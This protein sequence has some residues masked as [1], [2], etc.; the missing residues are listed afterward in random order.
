MDETKYAVKV[1][2]SKLVAAH[3]LQECRIIQLDMASKGLVM[4]L[5]EI[6]IKKGY[7]TS[8]QA[9][10]LRES[11]LPQRSSPINPHRAHGSLLQRGRAPSPKKLVRQPDLHRKDA[12]SKNGHVLRNRLAILSLAFS[13][14]LVVIASVLYLSLRSKGSTDAPKSAS[15]QSSTATKETV[16]EIRAALLD[17]DFVLATEILSRERSTLANAMLKQCELEIEQHAFEAIAALL[18]ANDEDLAIT[19]IPRICSR[20]ATLKEKLRGIPNAEQKVEAELRR[21]S[22]IDQADKAKSDLDRR[23][24]PLMFAREY[25]E[26][27]RIYKRELAGTLNPVLAKTLQA[28]I[29]QVERLQ[30]MAPD[31]GLPAEVEPLLRMARAALDRADMVNASWILRSA[32]EKAPGSAE[33]HG[34]F[35]W[36]HLMGNRYIDARS[37][38]DAA[39]RLDTNQPE[40]NY[41]VGFLLHQEHQHEKAIGYLDKTLAGRPAFGFAYIMRAYCCY[42][43]GRFVQAHRDGKEALGHEKGSQGIAYAYRILVLSLT[44]LG[45]EE[46][47]LTEC[48][49]WIAAQPWS[50]APY[51]HRGDLYLRSNKPE[52]AKADY[53]RALR[54][55]PNDPSIREKLAKAEELIRGGV[56]GTPPSAG[57]QENPPELPPLGKGDPEDPGLPTPTPAP[58]PAPAPGSDSGNKPG[59]TKVIP[60]V[61]KSVEKVISR[62]TELQGELYVAVL[63][64]VSPSMADHIASVA[65]HV[66]GSLSPLVKQKKLHIALATYDSTWGFV[67]QWETSLDPIKRALASIQTNGTGNENLMR[68]VE[69]VS[70]S[71]SAKR[72]NRVILVL[73][74]EVGSDPERL[75]RA[76]TCVKSSKMRVFV[77]GPEAPFNWGFGYE[78]GENYE[79]ATDAGPETPRFEILQ[80]SPIGGP[81]GFKGAMFKDKRQQIARGESVLFTDLGFDCTIGSGFGP[82]ALVRLAR[83]SGGEFHFLSTPEFDEGQVKHYSP[84]WISLADYER[85]AKNDRL[86][87]AITNIV[88]QWP[89][90]EGYGWTKNQLSQFRF[91]PHIVDRTSRT[92]ALADAALYIRRIDEQLKQLDALEIPKI[93]KEESRRWAANLD[94]LKAQ[95]AVMK[96]YLIQ[97][98]LAVESWAPSSAAVWGEL[99]RGERRTSKLADTACADAK[100]RLEDVDYKHARTPWAATALKHLERLGGF[101]IRDLK[102]QAPGAGGTGN[103]VPKERN[104]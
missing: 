59:D 95:L 28:R 89:L 100:R 91:L 87:W 16:S 83:E 45:K 22:L 41:V 15:P 36:C 77:V 94:L 3:Q 26:V 62:L 29:D 25:E 6:L 50:A 37:E 81:V 76:V 2:E 30:A 12:A 34:L 33:L 69:E 10:S 99:E 75:E 52:L 80:A 44:A 64:D 47:A 68:A 49:A 11:A 70:V 57:P 18:P 88:S 60:P 73:T 72:G 102:P 61:V 84:D 104:R 21:L 56:R 20:L 43:V 82:Y 7:L 32:L 79:V 93:K 9:A 14:V 39:L 98:I 46:E 31:G 86:R 85:A 1:L 55:E 38:A 74:D 19:E 65:A 66:E 48:G 13:L 97:Y 4:T 92:Q 58:S 78:A 54:I 101:D 24:G 90:P 27:L 67:T 51:V 23:V 63:V 42:N 71:L 103:P 35:A 17:N 5:E 40:A 53:E 8:L 96:H